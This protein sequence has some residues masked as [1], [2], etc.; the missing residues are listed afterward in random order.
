MENTT[1]GR[2]LEIDV[3]RGLAAS[4]VVVAHYTSYCLKHYGSVPFHVEGFYAFYAVKLF[5]IISGFVIYFTIDRSKTWVDFAFS[6]AT[7]LYPAH[8]AALT[9][10]VATQ[11]VAT[12]EPMWWGGYITNL[13][14]FQEYL[15]FPNL[16]FVYWSLTVELAFYMV[17]AVLLASGLIKHFEMIAAAWLLLACTWAL[18]ERNLGISLPAFLPRWLILPHAPFFIAGVMFYLI[19]SR[20]AVASRVG[21]I[22][23]A[24]ATIGWVDG[25][26][27]LVVS[28]GMFTLVGLALRG[29]LSFLVSPVTIWLG[30]I[31][32]PLYLIHR[33]LGYAAMDWMHSRD[34]PVWLLLMVTLVGALALGSLLSYGVERPASRILRRWYR[35]RRVPAAPSSVQH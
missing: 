11:A 15:G 8:W 3:L 21:L 24:L 5:F 27:N 14:M 18:F 7:R 31:S 20:G 35:T 16:D 10:W 9:I 22:V 34:I 25:I 17:M 1:Q 23:A 12:H 28:F 2:F 6:R 32:Y 30:T 33:N 4:C 13:T 19:H 29:R 26:E